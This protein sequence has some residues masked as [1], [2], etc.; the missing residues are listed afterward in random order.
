MFPCISSCSSAVAFE[1]GRRAPPAGIIIF[2]NFAPVTLNE[3]AKKLEK[4]RFDKIMALDGGPS[5][6]L[7]YKDN[8]IFSSGNEQ[9][10]VKSFLIIQK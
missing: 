2:S 8:E 1:Q 9:R 5:T 6:S 10:K 4:Y 3:A 7:N